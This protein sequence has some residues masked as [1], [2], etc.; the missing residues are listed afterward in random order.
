MDLTFRPGGE[1]L[2][3]NIKIIQDD[4]CFNF[5]LDSVLL[6]NFVTIKTNTKKILDLGTGNA[7]IP[8]IF[9]CLNEEAE[10]YGVEIQKKIYDMAVES[11]KMNKLENRIK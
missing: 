6:P 10:I 11:V 2:R 7:P 9:S 5:S 8:L 3:E 1:N 4:D